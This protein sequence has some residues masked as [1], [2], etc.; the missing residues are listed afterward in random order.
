MVFFGR[1][2]DLKPVFMEIDLS[3]F[4]FYF[5]VVKVNL[6]YFILKEKIPGNLTAHVIYIFQLELL[7]MT[8]NFYVVNVPPFPLKMW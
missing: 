4:F 2:G 8:E 6:D 5:S 3:V 7:N 1:K